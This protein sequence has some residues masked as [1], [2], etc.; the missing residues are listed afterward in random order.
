M[1]VLNPKEHFATF[2]AA[3]DFRLIETPACHQ[4]PAAQ[5]RTDHTDDGEDSMTHRNKL[6]ARPFPL[7]LGVTPFHFFPNFIGI[8]L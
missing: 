8:P 5:Q 3:N 2:R 4:S 1:P 7:L 6:L